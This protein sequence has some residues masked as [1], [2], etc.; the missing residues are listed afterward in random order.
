MCETDP[1][2]INREP[3]RMRIR[4]EQTTVTDCVT[5]KI[6]SVSMATLAIT[7]KFAMDTIGD[8]APHSSSSS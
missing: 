5:W 1:T 3:K 8:H 6:K 7:Q 4:R 2:Q